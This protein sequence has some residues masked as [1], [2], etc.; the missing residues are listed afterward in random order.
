MKGQEITQLNG[1]YQNFCS[2]LEQENGFHSYYS[3]KHTLFGMQDKCNESDK[4]TQP[5]GTGNT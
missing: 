4:N 2:H 3:C 5:E 1:F